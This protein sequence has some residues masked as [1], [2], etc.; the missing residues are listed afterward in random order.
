M[1]H[2]NPDSTGGVL[3]CFPY[4]S[5]ACVNILQAIPGVTLIPNDLTAD[6]PARAAQAGHGIGNGDSVKAAMAKIHGAVG[7]P[8]WDTDF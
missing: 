6:F 7:H 5:R 8:D 4:A 3:A 2:L 1:S